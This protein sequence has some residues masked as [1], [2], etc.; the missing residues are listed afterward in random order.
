MMSAEPFKVMVVGDVAPA[1]DA[2]IAF[3]RAVGFAAE[4]GDSPAEAVDAI[5]QREFDLAVLDLENLIGISASD[6]CAQIRAIGKPIGILLMTPTQVEKQ[7]VQALEA[8]ADDYITKPFRTAD[9]ISRCHVVLQRVRANHAL[10]SNSFAVGDLHLDV[11]LRQLRKAGKVVHLTPTEFSLLTFLMKNQG[12]ALTHSQLLRTIWGPEYGQELEYLRSY[13]R[14]LRKKI[15]A[16][17]SQPKYLL[18][19]PWVGYRLCEPVSPDPAKS[20]RPAL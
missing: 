18:T 14:L 3:L 1:R 20:D 4:H 6:L 13:I 5:R 11:D 15:E 2:L 12:T 7:I 9:L 10:E 8:G 19:E 17:P 16:Q